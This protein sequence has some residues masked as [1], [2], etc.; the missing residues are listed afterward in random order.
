MDTNEIKILGILK[1]TNTGKTH[2]KE[3][4]YDIDGIMGAICATHYKSPPKVMVV[5]EKHG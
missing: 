2:Q 3:E 4:V 5:E 1:S